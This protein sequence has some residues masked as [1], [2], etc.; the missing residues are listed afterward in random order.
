MANEKYWGGTYLGQVSFMPDMHFSSFQCSSVFQPAKNIIWKTSMT[1]G[2]IFYH[3]SPKYDQILL[4]YEICDG[5]YFIL[6]KD[7]K[8]GN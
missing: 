5:L 3:H 1:F 7:S 2:I 6:K 8:L 4:K